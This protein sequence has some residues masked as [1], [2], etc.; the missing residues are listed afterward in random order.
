MDKF[1]HSR[2]VHFA[3]LDIEGAEYGILEELKYGGVFDRA[4][5]VFCQV[6]R[7]SLH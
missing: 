6:R 7:H 4:G 1:L 5:V 3:T 2:L